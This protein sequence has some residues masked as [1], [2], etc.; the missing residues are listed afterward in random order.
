MDRDGVINREVD[1]LSS[2]KQI[3]ILPTVI[4]GLKLFN[5]K[6]IAVVVITN[7]PVVARGIISTKDL[8][9]INNFLLEKLK[10]K[11]V[12]LN[13]IYSCPHH[14][15]RNHNDIPK[16]ALRY[17]IIC[18]CRKPG[19]LMYKKALSVYNYPKVLGMIGDQTRDVMAG[20]KLGVHTVIVKTGLKGEDRIYEAAPDF[21][22]NNFLDAVT[23]LLQ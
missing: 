9:E 1:Y 21:I 6:N 11:G 12:F 19:I 7:Q 5:K 8:R 13:A 4:R 14:P 23:V 3:K 20:K 15:E 10:K 22:C 17:R 18:E 16:R 2:I